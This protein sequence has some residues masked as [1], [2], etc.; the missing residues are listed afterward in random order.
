MRNG[1][2]S[3]AHALRVPCVRRS[4]KH[5]PELVASS[6]APR[7][8]HVIPMLGQQPRCLKPARRSCLASPHL[9]IHHPVCSQQPQ[10]HHA[11]ILA[12][13]IL[14]PHTH[15][16]PQGPQPQAQESKSQ[17]PSAPLTYADRLKQG[18]KDAA[19]PTPS[20]TPQQAPQV[21]TARL[22]HSDFDPGRGSFLFVVLPFVV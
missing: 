16:L 5:R 13:V 8:M 12:C 9:A 21:C 20:S 1:T 2:Q 18:R 3:S 22:P 4:I 17:A 10:A 7:S 11:W 14:E 19:A 6:A 15:S